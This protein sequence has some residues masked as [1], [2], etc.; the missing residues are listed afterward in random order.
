MAERAVER[1]PRLQWVREQALSLTVW[2]QRNQ[3]PRTELGTEEAPR[4][5]ICAWQKM[6]FK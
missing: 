4:G 2:G 3:A 1:Y 5:N 6:D